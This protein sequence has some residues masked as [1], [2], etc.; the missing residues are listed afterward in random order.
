MTSMS[1]AHLLGF[2]LMLG[3]FLVV[4]LNKLALRKL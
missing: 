3:I 2:V 4:L 1:I